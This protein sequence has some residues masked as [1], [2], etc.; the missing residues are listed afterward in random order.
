MRAYVNAKRQNEKYLLCF[1]F[2]QKRSCLITGKYGDEVEELDWSVG[3]ILKA[4]ERLGI[5]DNTFV[6]FSSDHGGHVEEIGQAGNREGGH[7]GIYRGILEI[8]N[9]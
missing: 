4:I 8:F 1:I 9:W 2:P 7:N 6:M 5:Y 3:E